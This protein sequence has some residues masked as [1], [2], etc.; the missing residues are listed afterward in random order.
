M[1][2]V[3]FSAWT[4]LILLGSRALV[5][6]VALTSLKVIDVIGPRPERDN[7]LDLGQALDEL[8][9]MIGLD[10]VKRRSFR[11]FIHQCWRVLPTH[12]LR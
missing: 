5:C 1:G 8:H 4:E 6:D 10:G 2:R 9:E 11:L 12:F 7:V 3:S